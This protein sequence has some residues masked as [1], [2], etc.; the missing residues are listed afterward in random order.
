MIVSKLVPETLN[1]H[2][3]DAVTNLPAF[4]RLGADPVYLRLPWAFF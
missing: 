4:D 3:A 1:L 2:I